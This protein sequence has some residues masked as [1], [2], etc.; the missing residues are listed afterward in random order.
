MILSWPPKDPDETLDYGADWSDPLAGDTIALSAFT[1]PTGLT[2]QSE[3]NTTTTATVWLTGGTLGAN[4][5][6]L[7]R[8]TTSGGR[9]M[10]QT[11]KLAVRR[12]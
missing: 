4:Y 6:I 5:E 12:K 9:I 10:D 7:N 3:A 1:V 2:K 11:F 8:V